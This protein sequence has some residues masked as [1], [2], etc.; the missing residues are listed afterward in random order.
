MSQSYKRWPAYNT[1][2]PEKYE[3]KEINCISNKFNHTKK[4]K[5]KIGK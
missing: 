5:V 4:I 2:H 1:K 3:M